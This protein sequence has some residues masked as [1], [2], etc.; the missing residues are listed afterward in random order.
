[1]KKTNYQF[2]DLPVIDAGESSAPAG[3]FR[4]MLWVLL[5]LL[6]A[7]AA[8]ATWVTRDGQGE[9]ELTDSSVARPLSE[10][11]KEALLGA[12]AEST[13]AA[14]EEERL[15]ALA[16]LAAEEPLTLEEMQSS[17]SQL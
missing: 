15:E 2:T 9:P 11:E 3:T 1:M 4:P 13:A 14:T 12:L 5:A 16:D 17:I 6:V 7:S 8:T 10:R